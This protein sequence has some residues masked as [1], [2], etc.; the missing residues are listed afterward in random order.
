MPRQV[1]FFHLL[2]ALGH[3]FQKFVP[4]GDYTAELSF[5]NEKVKQTFHVEI[6]AGV[7]TR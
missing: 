4:S 2:I 5:G 6:A 1:E 7:V 3:C